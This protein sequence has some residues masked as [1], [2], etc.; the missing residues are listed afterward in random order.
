MQ[1]TLA[2]LARMEGKKFYFVRTGEMRQRAATKVTN[3]G[4]A[5]E[6]VLVGAI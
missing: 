3:G 4:W 1:Q 6:V 2:K 5:I